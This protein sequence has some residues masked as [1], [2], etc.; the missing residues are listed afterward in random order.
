MLGVAEFV[1]ASYIA[2]NAIAL[3]FGKDGSDQWQLSS[4]P[5]R[6]QT[7]PCGTN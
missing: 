2:R 5:I 1:S 3:T 6:T 4:F 7:K